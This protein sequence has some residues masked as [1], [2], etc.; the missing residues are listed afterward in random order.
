MTDVTTHDD[1]DWDEDVAEKDAPE[2]TATDEIV[3]EATTERPA[4]LPSLMPFPVLNKNRRKRAE[5][6]RK[7]LSPAVTELMNKSDVDEEDLSSAPAAWEAIADMED[8]L[9]M[10]VH[11]AAKPALD[12]WL[13][14][15]EDAEVMKAWA[16]YMSQ[17]G[18]ATASST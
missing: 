2:A 12:A 11:P 3:D 7:A 16:W 18:E 5:F 10:V 17:M 1:L 15:S 9:K 6:A 13:K 4:G 14:E 8:A